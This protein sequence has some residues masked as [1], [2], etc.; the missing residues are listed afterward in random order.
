MDEE[1][2]KKSFFN[3]KKDIEKLKDGLESVFRRIIDMENAV[4]VEKIDEKSPIFTSKVF[5]N[6]D[7]LQ[8]V[9]EVF[10]SGIFVLGEK[11]I[12]FERKFADFSGAKHAIAM[13]NGTVAIEIALKALGIEEGDE[14]IVPS[15]TTMPT[16]EPIL[17]LKAKPVFADIDEKTYTLDH[18]KIEKLITNK[19][20]AIMPV[21]IYGNPAN[22]KEMQKICKK[23]K[24]FLIEDCAQ[25][26][27]ARYDGKHVG[28]FGD[29]GCF[30][31]YPTKNLTVCGEGGMAVTDSDEI[32][33]KMRMLISHGENGRYNHV[34]LGHNYR[35]SEIHAAIG[36]KQL[37]LLNDFS[38]RRRYIAKLYRELLYDTGLV[39][40]EDQENGRHSYHLYVIRTDSKKRDEI[41][42]RLKEDNIHCGIHYPVPCHKQKIVKDMK[43]SKISL[44]VTEKYVEEII[45]LPIYPEL[46]DNEIKFISE[47]MKNV[48]QEL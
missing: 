18:T 40:P 9:K 4:P 35:L 11:T 7:M 1:K 23:H 36:I 26:H 15:F 48:L 25:A 27:N 6:N 43:L 41:I 29:I 28:T 45:S 44:P 2:I 30:S 39:L 17:H 42:K 32:A 3:L 16:I 24:L 47:R 34:I 19:T 46:K 8:A 13:A 22:M 37:E 31:F 21:H 20:K 5:V 10:E 38:E 14:V 33:R 12:E